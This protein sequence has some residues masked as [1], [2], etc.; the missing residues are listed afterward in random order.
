MKT[1]ATDKSQETLRSLSGCTDAPPPA[2][3]PLLSFGG[4]CLYHCIADDSLRGHMIACYRLHT[5]STPE[6]RHPAAL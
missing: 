3:R 2:V 6:S 5:Q 1:G 4:H